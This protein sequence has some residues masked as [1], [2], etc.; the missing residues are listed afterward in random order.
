MANKQDL[1]EADMLNYLVEGGHIL[2]DCFS[3][4]HL[5]TL[6]SLTQ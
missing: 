6:P 3:I 5:A 2:K 4:F 1:S